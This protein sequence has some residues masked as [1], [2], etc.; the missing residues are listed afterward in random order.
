MYTY[1]QYLDL[2]LEYRSLEQLYLHVLFGG[3]GHVVVIILEVQAAM[4]RA[5]ASRYDA[6]QREHL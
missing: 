1:I 6:G 5:S 4:Q 3:G 2:M